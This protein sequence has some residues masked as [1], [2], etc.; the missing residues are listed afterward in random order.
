MPTLLDLLGY[1]KSPYQLGSSCFEV[2]Q[3]QKMVYDNGNLLSFIY[4]G[5]NLVPIVWTPGIQRIYS[6]EEAR[7]SQQMSALYQFYMNSLLQ[8]RCTPQTSKA[9]LP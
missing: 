6:K 4:N 1:E 2:H 3:G 5:T 7:V 8:N 9:R